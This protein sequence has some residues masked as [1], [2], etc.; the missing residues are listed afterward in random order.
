MQN[1][2][3]NIVNPSRTEVMFE[4]LDQLDLLQTLAERLDFIFGK[5]CNPK[6]FFDYTR[7]RVQRIP[8][9]C[10]N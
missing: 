1:C 5:G 4:M 9:A 7:H 6:T 3:C 8:V 2:T 10:I